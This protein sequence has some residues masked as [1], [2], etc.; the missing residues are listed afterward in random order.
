MAIEPNAAIFDDLSRPVFGLLGIPVDA[1]DF[2][3]VISS[4][5]AAAHAQQP[6]LISTPNVNFLIL[7]RTNSEFRE[8]LLI[9][10]LCPVDG[11]P[12]VLIAKLLGVPIRTRV[13]GSDTFERLKQDDSRNPLSVFLFGGTDQ[14]AEMVSRVLNAGGGMR[15]VGSLN[16][17][18]GSVEELS[19]DH[20]IEQINA[21]SADL[22]AV[23]LSSSKAQGWLLRNHKKIRI[24][25][26]FDFGGTINFQ[27]GLVKRAPLRVRQLG[28]EWLWRIKEEPYLW[29][30]Y[31]SD[32]RQLL[33]IILSC[34]L[35]LLAHNFWRRLKKQLELRLQ[36]RED[37]F[38]VQV[39][40]SGDAIASHIAPAIAIFHA[41]CATQ[42]RIIVDL[43]DTA[44]IDPRFFGLFLMLRKQMK[45]RGSTLEF[46]G[47]NRKIR[48]IFA[49]NGFGFLLGEG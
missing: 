18:F 30:R 13:A 24:P 4:I 31:W 7:A 44:V 42:K 25:V 10:E 9:S 21:S 2:A 12:V 8:A 29:H 6:F 43:S 37:D 11:A 39:K 46:S 17:G 38:S 45:A 27:A 36:L 26:R 34:V 16:P 22:L 5:K 19:Q 40:L 35:P 3:T 23:F 15:C 20:F 33:V 41:A 47:T 49:L 1:V 32:G 14:A 28:L 48:R